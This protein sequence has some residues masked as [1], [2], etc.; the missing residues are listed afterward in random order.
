MATSC[1]APTIAAKFVQ[2]SVWALRLRCASVGG[3]EQVVSSTSRLREPTLCVRSCLPLDF[4]A[5]AEL[6]EADISGDAKSFGSPQAV[7]DDCETH[8][9]CLID[10]QYK[11]PNSDRPDTSALHRNPPSLSTHSDTDRNLLYKK[12]VFATCAYSPLSVLFT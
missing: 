10:S 4:E 5:S 11:P 8:R 7:T 1:P 9:D 12:E 3:S 6:G 2:E